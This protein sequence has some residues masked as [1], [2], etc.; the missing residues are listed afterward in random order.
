MSKRK[1]QKKSEYWEKFN[2]PITDLMQGNDVNPGIP[3]ASAGESFLCFFCFYW[4]LFEEW[5]ADHR[6]REE[7]TLQLFLL[8]KY[9][10]E[11]IA[12]GMLPFSVSSDGVDVKES[13]ELCQ[14]A[15]ANVPIFRNAIDIMA[16]LANSPIY[17]EQGNEKSRTFYKKMVLK[18]KSLVIK[19]SIF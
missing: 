10:F 1:Y 18:N 19:R 17:V 12:Q 11:N 15:Y 8:K 9:R 2:K 4:R 14:K 3:P 13:I 6:H 5:G 16:E 7:G